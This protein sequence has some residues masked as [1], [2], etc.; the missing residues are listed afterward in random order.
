M[1]NRVCILLTLNVLLIFAVPAWPVDI[2]VPDQYPTIQDAIAAATD[3]DTVIVRPGTYRENIDFLGKAIVLKSEQ[4]RDVTV[5]DGNDTASV[6]SFSSNEGLD[7]VLLGFTL[8]N[9]NSDR[10]GGIQCKNAS[11][12]I[13]DSTIIGNRSRWGGGIHVRGGDSRP[14]IAG[15]KFAENTATY[16]GGG[17]YSAESDLV[18]ENC[19]IVRNETSSSGGGIYIDNYSHTVLSG[20]LIRRNHTSGN[21][22]GLFVEGGSSTIITGN[23]IIENTAAGHGGGIYVYYSPDI[24]NNLIAGNTSHGNGG[25]IYFED[26]PYQMTQ[27][28]VYGN[29]AYVEGGGVFCE[30]DEDPRITNS[31]IRDNNA[32]TG[33]E[34]S[35]G[36]PILN[37]CNIKGGWQGTGNFDA[38]PMFADP[39]QGDFH[40]LQDPCQPGVVNP[41]VDAGDPSFPTI[42]GTTRTDRRQD[43]GIVDIGFHYPLPWIPDVV[44]VPDDFLRIQDAVNASGEG[45]TVVVRPGTYF[46]NI[47]ITE[48]PVVL[49]SEYGPALTVIDGMDNGRDSVV[50]IWNQETAGTV[51]DGFTITNGSSGYAGGGIWC[52]DGADCTIR[53]NIIT[54]NSTV[55][56][57]GGI[58][59]ENTSPLIQSNI[60]YDN[61]AQKGAGVSCWEASPQIVNNT[62]TRNWCTSIYADDKGGG[63]GCTKASFPVISNTIVWNNTASTGPEIW[64]GAIT[65]PSTLSISFSDVKGGQA[66]V[67]LETGCLIDWGPG[68]IDLDPVLAEAGDGDF[69]LTF[70][71]PCRDAGDGSAAA[72]PI[73]DFE[74]DPRVAGSSPDMGADEFHRHLYSLGDMIPG[75]T[76]DVR[77]VG[78][79]GT[80]PLRLWLGSGILE[81]AW[82]TTSGDFYLLP[83]LTTFPLGVIAS[84]HGIRNIE[85]KV[86][87]TWLSGELYGLQALVGDKLSNL[88]VLTV[89]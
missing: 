45:G 73:V 30:I 41:C 36:N 29:R 16:Y 88:M 22:A 43:A 40:L 39:V 70:G 2:Y 55:S 11:P 58:H 82:P 51:V 59:C 65:S 10:G 64:I 26:D 35:G 89:Q 81:E 85:A 52:G 76:I 56:R 32:P 6:V 13:S 54:N 3:D 7:S 1:K 50:L 67:S 61:S 17:I 57:G 15:N 69:H 19:E 37:Y 38:D 31:I 23:T 48:K 46:E 5:I 42:R 28:T 24:T 87:V 75:N 77:I 60:I 68:M 33:P 71:S 86:P 74:G 44:F 83:P 53:N 25:G 78:F 66:L 80:A 34:L 84:S 4:G 21:G 72:L 49:E 8:T 27:C 47:R 14:L 12:T 9:G 18:I 63:I 20:C 79:P 62:I